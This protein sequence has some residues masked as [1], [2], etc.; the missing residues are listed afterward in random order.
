MKGGFQF[1][2]HRTPVESPPPLSSSAY[3]WRLGSDDIELS[4]CTCMVYTVLKPVSCR[5]LVLP[6]SQI[7]RPRHP[8]LSSPVLISSFHSTI[9]ECS[10]SYATGE[11]PRPSQIFGCRQPAA[12]KIGHYELPRSLVW[13]VR[14]SFL[15]ARAVSWER[16]LFT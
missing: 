5:S 15:A 14:V 10:S 8:F 9:C 2:A 6:L 13:F 3:H 4:E 7:P 11:K 1:L 16:S 12:G